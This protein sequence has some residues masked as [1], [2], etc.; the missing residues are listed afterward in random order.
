MTVTTFKKKEAEPIVEPGL[1]VFLAS[2]ESGEFPMTTTGEVRSG[3]IICRWY[4]TSGALQ[5]DDFNPKELRLKDADP[6]EVIEF[7]PDFDVK[8]DG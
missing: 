1:V 4:D 7:H 6:E 3:R 2:D 5:G 8:T